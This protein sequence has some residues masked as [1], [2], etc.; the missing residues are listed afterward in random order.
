MGLFLIKWLENALCFLQSDIVATQ[1]CVTR[2]DYE[3]AYLRYV[4]LLEL[5]VSLSNGEKEAVHADDV[6]KMS[7][8]VRDQAASECFKCWHRF[9]SNQV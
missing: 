4:Y 6:L 2:A 7:K 1:R 8:L 9:C 5:Y 3:W